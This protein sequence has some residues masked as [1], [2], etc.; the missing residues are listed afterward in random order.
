MKTFM[1]GWP[2]GKLPPEDAIQVMLAVQAFL[3]LEPEHFD[4]EEQLTE[5]T[6]YMVEL[7]IEFADEE[8]RQ[9]IDAK[10]FQLFEK[11]KKD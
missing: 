11:F 10:A 6:A 5:F 9:K 2:K 7:G 4:T 3:E 8:T 1:S